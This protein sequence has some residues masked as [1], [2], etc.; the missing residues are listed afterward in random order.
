M[1][2]T[3]IEILS[4]LNINKPFVFKN[5]FNNILKIT[6]F[7]NLLNLTP[8]TNTFR[9]MPTFSI[10]EYHWDLPHWSTGSNHWPITI[11]NEMLDKGVCYMTD[12]SR[13]NSKINKICSTLEIMSKQPVDAHIYFNK[14]TDIENNFGV[15][16]DA[17]HNFIVQIDGTT[18]WK[19]GSKK[20]MQN[21]SNINNFY[22]DDVLSI[23]QILEPGDAMII[24]SNIFHGA[25]SLS[26]R[27]S[28]SFPIPD[29]QTTEITEQRTW[30]NW[31]A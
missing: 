24:P 23:D 13:V 28:I 16:K 8:F 4:N 20:Y 5:K 11:I 18:H 1:N 27:V 22:D 7:E 29:H 25:H 21:E 15:H 19:V 31:N 26:K 9:F 14:I 6:E 10:S 30:I 17:S 2:E 3:Q 12:C